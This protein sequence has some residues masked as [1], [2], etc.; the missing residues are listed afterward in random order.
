MK[1]KISAAILWRC[2]KCNMEISAL[3]TEVSH[4]CPSNNRQY[5]K[6]EVVK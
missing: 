4:R 6:W 3:A 1:Q 2:P 5:T